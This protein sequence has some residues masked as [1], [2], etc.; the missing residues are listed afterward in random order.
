MQQFSVPVAP[1]N[2][3]SFRDP[4]DPT[5]G[6]HRAVVRVQNIPTDLPL[7]PN[8]RPE[9]NLN[10]AVAR[11]IAKSLNKRDG[12]FHLL[13]RGLTIIAASA[14]YDNQRRVLKLMIDEGEGIL[15][16]GH[17][18]RVII[19]ANPNEWPPVS[20]EGGDQEQYVNVEVL[21]GITESVSIARARNTSVQVKEE[22]LAN[23]QDKFEWIKRA[24]SSRPY[25][26]RIGYH[27]F[28]PGDADIIDVIQCMTV[29]NAYRF[30]N[31]AS[32]QQHPVFAY[33]ASSRVLKDYLEDD[34]TGNPTYRRLEPILH[35]ILQ[36]RDYLE[37]RFPE[38]YKSYGGLHNTDAGRFGRLK[39]IRSGRTNELIFL[40]KSVNYEVPD[41]WLLPVLASLRVLVDTSQE[42]AM[43][44][45]DPRRFAD[46]IGSTLLEVLVD[47]SRQLGRNPNAVGKSRP[48]WSHLY[49]L[50]LNRLISR[51]S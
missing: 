47:T 43:W 5:I 17:T 32:S 19:E 10:Q 42:K 24:I 31:D 51:K 4:I 25:H 33:S 30:G 18:Y 41:G 14:A 46:E 22:S 1:D 21:T 35:D 20:D 3:R 27:E 44:K 39:E 50:S 15:D 23:L 37:M 26:D 36:L 49:V 8:P 48:L 6:F 45:T 7:D 40:Q 2:I 28:A 38:Y 34:K 12:K 29:L 16:G 9:Q 13:N 11:A